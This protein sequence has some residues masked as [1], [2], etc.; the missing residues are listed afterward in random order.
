MHMRIHHGWQVS[1][2]VRTLR[3][4][5]GR[6][7]SSRVP[8]TA[9]ALVMFKRWLNR[10]T[11]CS[12]HWHAPCAEILL[13]SPPPCLTTSQGIVLACRWDIGTWDSIETK[14][15]RERMPRLIFVLCLLLVNW[16]VAVYG[17]EGGGD[18]AITISECAPDWI[19]CGR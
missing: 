15:R 19:D 11:I 13:L 14:I 8:E 12:R 1:G 10:C 7:G 6:Q 3:I 18:E 17:E 4:M 9:P 16:T 2:K 5:E